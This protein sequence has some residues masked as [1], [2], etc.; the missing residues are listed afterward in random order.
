MGR[1][2]VGSIAVSGFGTWSYNVGIAVYAYEQTHS[3]TWVAAV[4]VGRYVPALILTWLA[5]SFVDRLPRRALA[6]RADLGCALI[7]G[8]LAV[9]GA[10]QAPVLLVT[11]LAAL[12]ST[13]AR[14]QASAVL[15]LAS[16][17]VVESALARMARLA[18]AADAV[19]TA[20][21]SAAASALLIAFSPAFLFAGNAVTFAVSALL[22]TRV[23]G[24]TRSA[25]AVT[26]PSV[27]A[28]ERRRRGDTFA[29]W[30]L[31]MARTLVAYVYGVDVVVLTVVASRQFHGGAGGYGWLLAAMGLGGLLAAVPIR[32][33]RRQLPM[34]VVLVSGILGYALPLLVFVLAPPTAGGLAVQVVRGVGSVLATSAAIAAL[35]RGVPSALAGRVFSTTQSL[36]LLGTCAGAVVTPILLGSLGFSATLMISA[37]APCVAAVALFPF[38]VRF[39]RQE[40]SLLATLDPRLTV[41]RGLHLLQDAS[42]STLYQ[43]ADGA[44]EFQV[45]AG[46][47]IIRQGDL[48][49]ALYV[50]VSGGLEVTGR[51]DSGP[52]VLRQLSSPDVF[53][54]IGLLRGI[55]R[56]STVTA[57]ATCTLWR[58]PAAIFLAGVT[59]AGVSGALND[60]VQVRLGTRAMRSGSL[61]AELPVQ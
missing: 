38:L 28:T 30:P 51:G 43:L 11:L 35:Q 34:P 29:F 19:S 39:D 40:A 20:A 61:R 2:V 7:M 37:I 44:E 48:A 3:A 15:S 5:R 9:A 60:I 12:S 54:E 49:D 23:S 27:A 45:D 46:T 24:P 13:L 21:G 50:L 8:G 18:G 10:L 32:G 47:V 4:T 26:T 58:I 57:T 22:L 17:V 42:R 33:R 25:P 1:F 14:V 31:Q 36:V 6:I 55:P 53:G 52:V 41:L 16:D 59:E 56:T